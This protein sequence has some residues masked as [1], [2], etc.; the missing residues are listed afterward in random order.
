MT[1]HVERVGNIELIWQVEAIAALIGRTE[2]QTFHL[3]KS[4]QL[5]ARKVGGRWVAEKSRLVRFFLEDAAC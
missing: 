2:R 5:P 3:L 4:G 1:A